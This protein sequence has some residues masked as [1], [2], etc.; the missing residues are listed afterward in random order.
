MGFTIGYKRLFSVQILHNYFLNQGSKSF[1]AMTQ[2]KKA[3]AMASYQVPSILKVIPSSDTA[4]Q[5]KGRGMSF[6]MDNTGFFVGIKIDQEAAKGGL[7]KPFIPVNDELRLRFFIKLIDPY[8]LNYSSLGLKTA[9]EQVYYFNNEVDNS[10]TGIAHLSNPLPAYDPGK[11]YEAGALIVDD[12]S[13]PTQL[14]QALRD[15]GSGAFQVADWEEQILAEDYL[16]PPENYVKGDVVQ[17]GNSLFEALVDPTTDP[18]NPT[19]WAESPLSHQ[20][21]SDNDLIRLVPE[22]FPV[23]I[24]GG[25][26]AAKARVFRPGASNPVLVS[27]LIQGGPI[28]NF[29]VDLR[30]LDPGP[31]T[32]ELVDAGNNPLQ[33]SVSGLLYM[34]Q[35][36]YESGGL[37]IIE[38]I[39]KP[40]EDQGAYQLLDLSDQGLLFP[41][42]QLRFKNRS[43]YWRYIF[44]QEQT[45]SDAQLGEFEREGDGNEKK[46]FK[47]TQTKPLTQALEPLKKFDTDILLPNPKADLVKPNV[48]D[49]QIYSEIYIHS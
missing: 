34:D 1:E 5:M 49:G 26:N 38:I 16:R 41:Q 11:S 45:I 39:H 17:S 35:E 40:G 42:Y 47:T 24:S 48:N 23:S 27:D 7:N 19:Q 13:A 8:F 2:Q 4:R 37:G 32:L 15:T 14:F 12:A 3:N 9:S 21:A 29:S 6:R 18:P 25:P 33:S 10:L 31:Y 30:S 36:L 43:T 20:Y 46:I 28:S 22:V 44:N